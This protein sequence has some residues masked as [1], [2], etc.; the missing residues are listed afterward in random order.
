MELPKNIY[1]SITHF[2]KCNAS[3]IAAAL[4]YYSLF[5]LGPI[6]LI[7]FFIL[8]LFLSDIQT[9]N[10]IVNELYTIFPSDMAIVINNVIQHIINYQTPTTLSGFLG[11]LVLVVSSTT[12]VRELQKAL[13]VIFEAKHP[14]KISV[15]TRVQNRI[16]ALGFVFIL[17]L[18]ILFTFIINTV[19]NAAGNYISLYIGFDPVLVYYVNII[20]SLLFVSI[21]FSL[22]FKYLPDTDLEWKHIISGGFITGMLFTIGKNIIAYVLGHANFNTLYGTTGTFLIFLIWVYYTAIIFLF[23][24]CLTYIFAKESRTI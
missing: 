16:I 1:R 6:F 24:A 19:L 21:L 2:H 4:S 8:E 12:I 9:Q 13:N 11:I 22:L 20:I 10:T 23:G 14:D 18:L 5:A 15:T 17:G 3:Q 7:L